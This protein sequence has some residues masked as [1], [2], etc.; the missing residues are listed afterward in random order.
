MIR[1]RNPLSDRIQRQNLVHHKDECHGTKGYDYLDDR[2]A[3]VFVTS[4]LEIKDWY[5]FVSI[6]TSATLP[7]ALL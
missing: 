5:S 3:F 4:G 6:P 7:A 1:N 2:I